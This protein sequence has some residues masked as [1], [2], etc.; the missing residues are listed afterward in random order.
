MLQADP[1]E[2]RTKLTWQ[3]KLPFRDLVARMVDHDLEHTRVE[4]M[5]RPTHDSSHRRRPPVAGDVVAANMA[6]TDSSDAGPFNVG[7]DVETSI[8]QLA[9]LLAVRAVHGPRAE[10]RPGRIAAGHRLHPSWSWPRDGGMV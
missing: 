2:A 4:L 5:V 1:T 10:E 6:A 8:N 3:P 7:T 9:S